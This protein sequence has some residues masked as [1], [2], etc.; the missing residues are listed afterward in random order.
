MQLSHALRD[1][2]HGRG[3]AQIGRGQRPC[4]EVL[5][6]PTIL[7]GAQHLGSDVLPPEASQ[8]LQFFL[9]VDQVVHLGP[10]DPEKKF[11]GEVSTKKKKNNNNNNNKKEGSIGTYAGRLAGTRV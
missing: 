9:A 10:I 11:A 8:D 4:L 7:E 6:K 5:L 3:V 1:L 2:H